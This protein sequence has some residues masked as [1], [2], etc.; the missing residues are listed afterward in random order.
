ML[1]TENIKLGEFFINKIS[2]INFVFINIFVKDLGFS[3]KCYDS[4]LNLSI[5][6]PGDGEFQDVS[7]HQLNLDVRIDS[8]SALSRQFDAEIEANKS[9]LIIVFIEHKLKKKNIAYSIYEESHF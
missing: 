6:H 5:E 1:F 3:E 7:I 2:L 9:C 4:I 8:R